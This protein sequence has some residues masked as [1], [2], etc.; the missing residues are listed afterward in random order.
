MG[1]NQCRVTEHKGWTA[2][3]T[4]DGKEEYGFPNKDYTKKGFE[5]KGEERRGGGETIL[6]QSR[7]VLSR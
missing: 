4:P 7:V 1:L 3:R 6:L 2:Y 5:R